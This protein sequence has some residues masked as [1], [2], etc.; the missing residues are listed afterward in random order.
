MYD[1]IHDLEQ[2]LAGQ[3]SARHRAALSAAIA[4]VKA[5]DDCSVTA[6]AEKTDYLIVREEAEN[7]E[8]KA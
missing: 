5:L 1:L 4:I 3:T 7:A 8:H 6:D 2:I